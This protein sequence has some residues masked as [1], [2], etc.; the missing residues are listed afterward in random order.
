MEQNREV[1]FSEWEKMGENDE[2]NIVSILK[3][4]DGTPA[5]VCFLSQQMAEKYLKGLLLFFS[6][7]CPKIHS[8]IKL[9]A[10]IK[11]HIPETEEVLKEEAS[12]LDA[13]YIETR[14]VSD[15]PLETYTWEMAEEAYDAT[16][17]IKQFTMENKRGAK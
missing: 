4:R 17:K 2:L 7:D 1:L 5:M 6:G 10:L 16:K 8:L 9:I 13:Y 14:Y 11:L 3:H 12:L 15:I